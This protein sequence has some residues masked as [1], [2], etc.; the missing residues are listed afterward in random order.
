MN[1]DVYS[2]SAICTHTT[3]SKTFLGTCIR[4]RHELAVMT[5]WEESPRNLLPC[6]CNSTVVNGSGFLQDSISDSPALPT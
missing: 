2:F 5:S 6:F 1:P 3:M 4:G